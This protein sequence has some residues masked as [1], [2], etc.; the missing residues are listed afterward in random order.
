LKPRATVGVDVGTSVTKGAVVDSEGT[1]IRSATREHTVDR[2][3]YLKLCT[4]TT[5]TV[6]ALAARESRTTRTP[7]EE[8]R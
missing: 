8:S 3:P 5:A 2:P 4:S 7:T 6:H 1:L